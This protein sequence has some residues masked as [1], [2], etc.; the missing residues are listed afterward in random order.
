MH[1]SSLKYKF[2][3]SSNISKILNKSHLNIIICFHYLIYF[4][5]LEQIKFFCIF[6]NFNYNYRF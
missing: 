5:F 1:I 4:K 2:N 6:Y 3:F